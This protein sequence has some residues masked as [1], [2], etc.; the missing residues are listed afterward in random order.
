MCDENSELLGFWTDMIFEVGYASMPQLLWMSIVD[1]K[2]G[3]N[4]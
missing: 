3:Q 1:G 2:H 4:W